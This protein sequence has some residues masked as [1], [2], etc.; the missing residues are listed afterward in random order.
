[1]TSVAEHNQMGMQQ[2]L[3]YLRKQQRQNAEEDE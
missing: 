3:E 2:D 1:M